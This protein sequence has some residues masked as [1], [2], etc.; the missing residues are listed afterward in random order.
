MCRRALIPFTHTSREA[1]SMTRYHVYDR[2][3]TYD[4]NFEHAPDVDLTPQRAPAYPDHLAPPAQMGSY[5]FCGLPVE[6]PLGIAAGPLL[7]GK[8]LVYY[9]RLGYSTL[10]YKT[11]RCQPRDSYPLP[12]LQPI[13]ESEIR[14]GD[15]VTATETTQDSWAISFGMPSRH[16]DW[17]QADIRKA[18]A[19]L[20]S[21]QRL[22]VSV[23][24]SPAAE[25]TIDQIAADYA[26][27]AR[28]A[29]E[30]GADCIE[31]NLSCP[32]VVSADGR[33][34]GHPPA[35]ARVAHEV[36]KAV[37]HL[38]LLL[39]I[40]FVPDALAAERLVDAVAGSCNGLSMVNC[41]SARVK[42]PRGLLFDGQP[43]G[44]GGTA[45]RNQCLQ[46]V[47]RFAAAIEK[48]NVPL[49]L[50]GVGG[51]SQPHHIQ[52]YLD[53]GAEAVHVATAAILR[54]QLAA[55]WRVWTA[56]RSAPG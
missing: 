55:E 5:T 18:L 6:S 29:A 54:P 16:P 46:Q 53:A 35:A 23:V 2:S 33:L 36:H 21:G 34:Y 38:P 1:K 31:L 48:L 15:L 19:Q 51:I 24:A 8:W 41:L 13:L 56:A 14:D 50:I 3:Q 27:C 40:G 49:H 7:N 37:P 22:I 43:R 20:A 17:W 52:S 39:K 42:G 10:T 26:Q 12:N 25:W 32:N 11:V 4:W 28:R 45:I 47:E 44:I 9:A 30:T